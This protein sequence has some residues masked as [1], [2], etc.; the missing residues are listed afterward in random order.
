MSKF[1]RLFQ[2]KSSESSLA[3][4]YAKILHAAS[5]NQR[6]TNL[7][8]WERRDGKDLKPPSIIKI[9]PLR[10][11]PTNIKPLNIQPV[12]IKQPSNIKTLNIKPQ[13]IKPTWPQYSNTKQSRRWNQLNHDNF[14]HNAS[15]LGNH[16]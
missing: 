13:N 9:K 5:R 8:G 12:K 11:T 15:L 7:P 14:N 6:Y 10:L 16:R 1:T 3:Q 2:E 4:K